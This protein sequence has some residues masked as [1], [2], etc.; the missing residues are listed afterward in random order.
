MVAPSSGAIAVAE[1]AVAAL[2]SAGALKRRF[3]RVEE[4]QALWRPRAPEARTLGKGSVFGHLLVD[5][6]KSVQGLRIP[7]VKMTWVRFLETVLP[8]A[9]RVELCTDTGPRDNYSAILTASDLNAPPIM[10]W[11]S[12]EQRNP[13]SWYVWS[14]GSAHSQWGL[15]RGIFYPVT[16]I[17]LQPS[18]WFGDR[19]PQQGASAFFLIQGCRETKQV[20]TALFPEML[21]NEYHGIRAVIEAHSKADKLEGMEEAT[22]CGVRLQ[23]NKS[24]TPDWLAR[25]RTHGAG[26]QADFILDRWE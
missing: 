5:S 9:E 19:C 17:C 13:F 24:G 25:V 26:G 12:A 3:A 16:A 23:K 8:N 22:A 21:R 14:G 1:K 7:P 18:Q 10:Q 15:I 6:S 4:V 2:G 11:D 20:G